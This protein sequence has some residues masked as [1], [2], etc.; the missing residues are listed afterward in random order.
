[1][2]RSPSAQTAGEIIDRCRGL[3]FA[4]AGI[5]DASPTRYAEELREWLGQGRHGSMS[6][7]AEQ[8]AARLDPTRVLP[9]ARSVIMVADLYAPRGDKDPP[10]PPGH[11]RIAR[12]AR[13]RDYHT[14]IKKRLHRLCDDLRAR[15]PGAEFRAFT[16]SAP[17]LEREYAA[18][19]GLGWTGKH[20]LNIHPRLGSYMLLGGVLTTLDLAPGEPITDHCGTCTR[21]IDACPTHA[22][23]PYSVDASR[24]I[25]YLTIERRAPIDPS[26]QPAIGEW[27]FGCDICQDVC[28][29]NSARPSAP[30]PLL[31]DYTPRRTSLDLL[32]VLDWSEDDRR[33]A[34]ES[35]ALKRATLAMMKRN[36]VIVAA[37]TSIGLERIREIAA[38]AAEDPIAR[39]A[40]TAAL[41]RLTGS[42]P[43]TD[44]GST[45]SPGH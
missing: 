31:P 10:L 5:A 40:A 22:I 14:I 23:S 7:L 26:L 21:C 45:R 13:G 37:N 9:G 28:P 34:F 20:T 24:C 44:S 16:D 32:D 27:L 18:R 3:G 2:I 1:M 43:R 12:Y 41:A 33:R 29:H 19:A 8:L 30:D 42:R 17:V 25:A 39:D 15:H 6:Y 11:G 38:S 36:A 4:L 35:S